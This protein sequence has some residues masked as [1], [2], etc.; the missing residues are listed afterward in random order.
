[1]ADSDATRR[2]LLRYYRV[3]PQKVRAV[4]LGVEPAFRPVELEAARALAAERYGLT[5]PFLL[6]VGTLEPRKN[7][8]ALLEA[9]RRLLSS[10]TGEGD[11]PT[12]AVAGA[13][14]W[15]YRDLYRLARELGLDGRVRF[16]GRVPDADLP[17]LYS[18]AAA[19]VYPSLYEGFGLPPLEALACGTPVV[20]SDRSSLPE[21]VGD[22][23]LLVDPTQPAA[24][25]GALARILDDPALRQELR[26]RGLERAAR[27]TWARTAA[28]T[29][30][31]Y[32]Q[33]LHEA[34]R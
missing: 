21:V 13:R 2:D 19:F 9:Y 30:Q 22:A 26:G 3:A 25:A 5:S 24:L 6:F 18:A 20:C 28:E 33:A 7:L 4:P 15:W 14:G 23:G 8:R 10:H 1:I 17:P 34:A 32:E 31:V 11:A 29:V 12:L 27:Y 16:L